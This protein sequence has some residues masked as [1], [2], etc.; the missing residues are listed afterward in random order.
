MS[1]VTMKAVIWAFL[2]FGPLVF[3]KTV[4]NCAMPPFVIQSF[5]PL[6]TYSS[7]SRV[8]CV[9]TLAAS[10][11]A[12]GSVRQNAAIISPVASFG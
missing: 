4:K 1:L 5:S 7:P 9:F 11:P 8:A 10:E 3:A 12:S 6:R 2:S